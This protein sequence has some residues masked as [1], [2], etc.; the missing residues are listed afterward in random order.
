[1][2]CHGHF[3]MSAENPAYKKFRVT[4]IDAR[5][6]LIISQE[7]RFAGNRRGG[8]LPLIAPAPAKCL[9]QGFPDSSVRICLHQLK[10]VQNI[11]VRMISP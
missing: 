7:N 2:S 1:M 10:G 9:T 8:Y 11:T 3:T 6:F 4:D 5:T